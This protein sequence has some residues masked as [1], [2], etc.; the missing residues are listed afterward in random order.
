MILEDAAADL[1]RALFGSAYDRGFVG[2]GHNKI[3]VYVHASKRQWREQTPS[4]WN[5]FEVEF[6]FGIGRIVAG[7]DA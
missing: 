1:K 7:V 4:E 6:R 3:F 2:I 5:G